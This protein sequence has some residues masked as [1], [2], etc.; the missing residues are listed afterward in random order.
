MPNSVYATPAQVDEKV[1]AALNRGISASAKGFKTFTNPAAAD[2]FFTAT[3][4][5]EDTLFIYT[6]PAESKA[7][8]YR[9][10]SDNTTQVLKEAGLTAEDKSTNVELGSDLLPTGDAVAKSKRHSIKDSFVF[11]NG[12]LQNGTYRIIDS[13][14]YNTTRAI[15]I[16]EKSK[17]FL[18]FTGLNTA[19]DVVQYLSAAGE[20][21]GGISRAAVVVNTPDVELAAMPAGTRQVVFC[22]PDDGLSFFDVKIDDASNAKTLSNPKIKEY[23]SL[24][25][26]LPT[27]VNGYLDATTG[28]LTGNSTA[29]KTWQDIEVKDEIKY[30][31]DQRTNSGSISTVVFK[32]AEGTIL[33]KDTDTSAK[34]KEPIAMPTGSRYIDLCVSSGSEWFLGLFC[35]ADGVAAEIAKPKKKELLDLSDIFEFTEGWYLD[36]NLD[37]TANGSGA[38]I[39]S[40]PVIDT[41]E[42]YF[43][44]ALG[45]G[46]YAVL[47]FRDIYGRSLGKILR[48]AQSTYTDE[49]LTNIAG[50][51]FLTVS[52]FN[53]SKSSIKLK[54]T[55]ETINKI[56]VAHLQKPKTLAISGSN[57]LIVGRENNLYLDNFS[58]DPN[59]VINPLYYFSTGNVLSRKG[60][61]LTATPSSAAAGFN[62]RFVASG[63][64]EKIYFRVLSPTNGAGETVYIVLVGDSKYNNEYRA[65]EVYRLLNEDADFDIQQVGTRGTAAKHEGR[66]GWRWYDYVYNDTFL[67]LNNAFRSGGEL[68]FAQYCADQGIPRID[69]CIINLGTND[70]GQGFKVPTK[71]AYDSIITY[72][73]EFVTALHADFPNCKTSIGLQDFGAPHFPSGGATADVFRKAIGLYNMA[74]H[75][76]F[77]NGKF[78][79][80]VYTHNGHLYMDREN[81]YPYASEQIDS[82]NADATQRVYID[83]VHPTPGMAGAANTPKGYE[84]LAF[85]DY[86]MIRYLLTL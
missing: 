83:N 65:K 41:G 77:F 32:N 85:G 12:Y 17:I 70:V 25:S 22:V 4:P 21:L 55:Q 68:D 45:A 81:N 73:K 71:A 46:S 26:F 49:L 57:H 34:Y 75:D 5:S 69:Y 16:N 24:N 10:A 20:R 3:P 19:Y 74:I 50:C 31:L 60:K 79:S 18:T 28:L 40:F 67:G 53:T 38:I 78:I 56:V 33:D 84:Q 47:D 66:S 59:E 1:Q 43:S 29:W 13:N 7:D 44:G 42:I 54:A 72:A 39:E 2:A 27:P 8:F 62:H 14:D 61:K 11:Q 48:S 30:Y 86:S 6:D 52:T 82:Y 76:N 35:D 9:R 58:I 37:Y 64:T 23:I 15:S 80:N 63:K 51:R 36:E